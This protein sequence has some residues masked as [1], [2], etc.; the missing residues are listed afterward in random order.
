MQEQSPRVFGV[1]LDAQTRC[2]HY[3]SALDV[4]AIKMRCCGRYF[5]CKECHDAVEAHA[6]EVWPRAEWNQPAVLCG[7]CR[8]EMSV[9][10]YMHCGNICPVCAAHFNPGC[11]NHYQFYFERA[12]AEGKL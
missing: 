5:A 6:I 10:E 9:R 12:D 3:H 2:V 7:V 1:G 4:I 11:R 8:T